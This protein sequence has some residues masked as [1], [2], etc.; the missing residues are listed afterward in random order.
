MENL[1]AL[2]KEELQSTNGGILSLM[3]IAFA[4]G[5][6]YGYVKEKFES[7]QWKI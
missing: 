2:S 7:G 4:E 1:T 6:A 3:L 5:V